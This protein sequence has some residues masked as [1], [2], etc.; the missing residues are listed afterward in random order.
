MPNTPQPAPTTDNHLNSNSASVSN[1]SDKTTNASPMQPDRNLNSPR[2]NGIPLR[3]VQNLFWQTGTTK[4]EMQQVTQSDLSGAMQKTGMQTT[5]QAGPTGNV[6]DPN[7]QRQTVPGLS[8]NNVLR[9][10]LD[11]ASNLEASTSTSKSTSSTAT[12]D[13][14]IPDREQIKSW[15]RILGMMHEKTQFKNAY[16]LNDLPSSMAGVSNA[17]SSHELSLKEAMLSLLNQLGQDDPMAQLAGQV[18]DQI[19]GQQL[20]LRSDS[21]NVNQLTFVIPVVNQGK[22]DQVSIHVETRSSRRGAWDSDNCRIWFDLSMKNIG[23]TLVDVQIVQKMVQIHVHNDYSGLQDW[24]DDKRTDLEG[25]I[26]ELDYRLVSFKQ[27][28]YPD[29]SQPLDKDPT[30]RDLTETIK[31]AAPNTQA[32]RNL[33]Y[34]GVDFKA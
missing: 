2:P 14:Q 26:R 4:P 11:V 20:L 30:N 5:G 22:Q 23:L 15:F 25:S 1:S 7:R 31:P 33:P 28:P 34:Q 12:P 10:E 18:S 19:T 29:G 13:L 17:P 6:V 24:M 16:H 27:L 3:P 9:N 8:S 32:Y 21:S